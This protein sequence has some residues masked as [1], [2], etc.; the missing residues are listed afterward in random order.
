[1]RFLLS[2]PCDHLPS[3]TAF[4]LVMSGQYW[5]MQF[6]D[7]YSII[8]ARY[9][10]INIQLQH[11]RHAR[12]KIQEWDQGSMTFCLAKVLYSPCLYRHT[13]TLCLVPFTQFWSIN[14]LVPTGDSHYLLISR[15]ILISCRRRIVVHMPLQYSLQDFH[16]HL[17][18]RLFA[19]SNTHRNSFR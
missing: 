4:I 3:I 19:Q 11:T 9:I 8:N 12:S 17:D 1:M 16:E 5:K 15:A 14:I 13:N 10:W 6:I 7:K 2:L 18:L